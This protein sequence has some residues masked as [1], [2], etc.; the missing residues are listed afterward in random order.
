MPNAF[1]ASSPPLRLSPAL[2]VPKGATPLAGQEA[3]MVKLIASYASQLNQ[4]VEQAVMFWQAENWPALSE[5]AHT[6]KGSAANFGFANI[7]EH[8]NQIEQQL[9]TRQYPQVSQ[10]I[11][12]ALGDM[13][14]INSIPGT[15]K[16]VG[17]HNHSVSFSAWHS[18]MKTFCASLPPALDKM[19]QE[20]VLIEFMIIVL[21]LI[22]KG[23]T[24]PQIMELLQA[25]LV[26]ILPKRNLEQHQWSLTE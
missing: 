1:A 20:A 24:A 19:Q 3:D 25:L 9:K 18:A 4:E 23:L 13:Q 15:D 22:V 5:L 11:N 10:L 17:I 7:G 6:V 12:Q 2:P 21:M 16:A 26:I 14:L 8:F